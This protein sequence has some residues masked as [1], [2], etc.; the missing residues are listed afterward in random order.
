[1]Y[2]TYIARGMQPARTLKQL[3]GQVR[4]LKSLMLRGMPKKVNSSS[5]EVFLILMYTSDIKLFQLQF[6]T[7]VKA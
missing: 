1:M 3:V 5:T 7:K 6:I 2:C 4:L